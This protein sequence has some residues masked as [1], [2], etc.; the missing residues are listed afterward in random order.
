MHHKNK[1]FTFNSINNSNFSSSS[2]TLVRFPANQWLDWHEQ[3]CHNPASDT[4]CPDDLLRS[5]FQSL[6]SCEHLEDINMRNSQSGQQA[7]LEV[8]YSHNFP[9]QPSQPESVTE[10]EIIDYSG[11]WNIKEFYHLLQPQFSA[12]KELNIASNYNIW[13]PQHTLLITTFD[14]DS[15]CN[16]NQPTG[17][18]WLTQL[19]ETCS[20]ITQTKK[21]FMLPSS[22]LF[23]AENKAW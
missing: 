7:P 14:E 20:E 2:K 8:N 22:L 12:V 4:S 21:M 23:K 17:H 5:A 16:L 11:D 3:T 10:Q 13:A 9:G 6:T 18:N 1:Y 15:P 19:N